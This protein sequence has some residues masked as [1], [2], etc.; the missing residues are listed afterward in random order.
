[1]NTNQ[2]MARP[3]RLDHIGNHELG[4]TLRILSDAG[5]NIGDA[6]WLRKPG[7]AKELVEL[8]RQAQYCQFTLSERLSACGPLIV[9]PCLTEKNFPIVG[10]AADLETL[11]AVPW[12]EL[13]DGEVLN[14]DRET[15]I[16]NAHAR[17]ATLID[18][19]VWAK[20]VRKCDH[21][22]LAVG[23]SWMD[24]RGRRQVP[25]FSAPNGYRRFDVIHFD[26]SERH[27]LGYSHKQ[28][29]H[30]FLVVRKSA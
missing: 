22:V 26:M 28:I 18:L 2:K 6:E 30:R 29:H 3:D 1:M 7:N 19:A 11:L 12:H 15:A 21:P 9:A 10:K 5:A 27:F 13:G 8:M 16:Y 20:E 17:P 24:E 4:P 23:S 25:F 14:V